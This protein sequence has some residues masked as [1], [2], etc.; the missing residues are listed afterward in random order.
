MTDGSA[1]ANICSTTCLQSSDC[2][3]SNGFTNFCNATGNGNVCTA[4]CNPSAA[5]CGAP[6]FG[7]WHEPD[8]ET[9]DTLYSFCWFDCRSNPQLCNY[10]TTCNPS[11]GGCVVQPCT[12]SS[13]CP[14]GDVCGAVWSF[15]ECVP[16]CRSAGCRDNVPCDTSNGVC[17]FADYAA[18][19]GSTMW[20]TCPS[21][22][23]CIVFTDDGNSACLTICSGGQA[24]P[25]NQTCLLSLTNGLEAC[26]EPCVILVTQCPAGTSCTGTAGD[27]EP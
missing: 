14:A 25:S 16:D 9:L 22:E 6:G 17:Q 1:S 2:G 10:G 27:C 4:G 15:N 13:T 12:T 23:A 11:T 24:C 19:N 3:T 7:C 8:S 26:S 20:G 21:G 18:C 5:S